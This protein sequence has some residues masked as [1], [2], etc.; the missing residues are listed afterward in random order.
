ME[1]DGGFYG[2]NRRVFSLKESNFKGMDESRFIDLKLDFLSESKPEYL[3]NGKMG[4][5]LSAFGS[6]RCGNF[7]GNDGDRDLSS[8][9]SSRIIVNDRGIKR[10]RKI[11]KGWRWIF[12][13]GR[14]WSWKE[15][16]KDWSMRYGKEGEMWL[17]ESL[18]TELICF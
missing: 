16:D 11:M 12:R 3:S 4:D 7:M 18:L 5:A 13:Q 9:G 14:G 1:V 6:T 15:E 17:R 10:G 2:V 8:G